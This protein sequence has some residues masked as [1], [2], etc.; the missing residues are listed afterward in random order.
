MSCRAARRRMSAHRDGELSRAESVCLTQHLES[1]PDCHL[2]WTTLGEALDL[3]GALPK[4]ASNESISTR[5]FDRLDMENRKP[6][7]ALLFRSFVARRP[8]MLPSLV[9][10]VLVLAAVAAGTLVLEDGIEL[11]AVHRHYRART[12]AWDMSVPPAGTEM[13]PLY[14]TEERSV[15]RARGPMVP[16]YLL[17]QRGEGSLFVETVV[18]RDGTVSAVNV[19]DGDLREVAP[20]LSA[21]RRERF[22]PVRLQ[23]RPVAVSVYRLISR[24]EVR[25]PLT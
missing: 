20:V 19:I 25:P 9:P 1:C 22:D 13:N 10:A 16:S 17:E 6:G 3:L 7:L 2:R 11:P 18:A 12:E 5:I 15:P 23:G 8:L 21:L 4:Q 24:M 14:P